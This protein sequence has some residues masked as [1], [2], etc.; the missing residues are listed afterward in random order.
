M[1]ERFPEIDP[2]ESGFLDAGEGQN[3]Y[4]EACGTPAGKP[5]VVLHGVRALGAHRGRD[6][7][8]ILT[9]IALSSWTSEG[10]DAAALIHGRCDLGSPIDVAWQLVRAWPD[11]ELQA[12]NTGHTGGDP[13]TSLTIEATNRFGGRR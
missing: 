9:P 8:S 7:C 4:W 13:V 12:V 6:A 5:V 3:L 2:Y 1:P 11:A 10:Q